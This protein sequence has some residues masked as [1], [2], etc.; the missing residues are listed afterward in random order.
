MEGE[1]DRTATLI[2]G[3]NDAQRRA[4]TTDGAPLAILAGA[5]SGKTRV[6]TRRI[7][8]RV[9]EGEIDASHVLAVT[10]TRKA[11]AE[12]RDRL[13]TLGLTSGVQAGT[14]HSIAFAQLRQ[15]WQERGVTPPSILDRKVGF[16]ARLVRSASSRQRGSS[17]LP[18]DLVSEIEWAK[19]RMVPADRY[20]E[21]AAAA[22]RRPPIDANEVAR[23]F[24]KYEE[25]KLARRMVDFDD[26]L[27]LATRDLRV[28]EGYAA[29]RR[30]RYRHLFVDEFQ[31]VN[32]LQFE[33]LRAWLGERVDLCVVGDPNQAIYSWNGADASYLADFDRYFPGATTVELSENYRSSPQILGVA[34][35]V[36]GTGPRST[37]FQLRPNRGDGPIPTVRALPDEHAEA[38]AIARRIR[39]HHAPGR[40]WSEQA[41]LVRTNAQLPVIEE[42]LR[43]ARVPFRSRGG[44]RLLEQPEVRETL[45]ALRRGP[46]HLSERL[47]EIEAQLDAGSGVGEARLSDER[48]ANVAEL[49]RL[50]REYVDLD[51]DGSAASFEAWLRS[52]LGNDE[53][54]PSTDAVD[55]ATF[56]AAKGLEW[57]VVHLA[58]LEE[59]FVPIHHAQT[60]PTRAEE[61]RL[62]YVALTR[63]ERELHCTWAERRAFASRSLQ[64]R[65]S[66]YLETISL[67][68]DL[69]G[70]GEE[71][72]D[73]TA[74][75]A[76]QRATLRLDDGIEP[77]RRRRP[78]KSSGPELPSGDRE[79]F[80]QLKA[81]RRAQA[82]LAD[83][84]AFVIFNDATLAEVATA[85]P[86]T[87]G[88]LLDVNGIG[89]V[90]A[91][92]FGEALLTIVAAN[93]RSPSAPDGPGAAGRSGRGRA[94]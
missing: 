64:R 68:I 82:K 10:F 52:T 20:A 41:V 61:R 19:A 36:L 85:R 59:G 48:A 72:I 14:F 58:G 27:R 46:G 69:L 38:R 11:A 6:L 73:L 33:L 74:A 29:A 5:G 86:A 84:P 75:V 87:A 78:T 51:A 81:W 21:A 15:R 47:D 76:R 50:G 56:H 55:L 25:E 92:R 65:P 39:D 42:A 8:R 54:G 7:A 43:V 1:L 23:V 30:W 71:P 57:S 34:N 12:L 4:V 26:L 91:Q 13:S 77:A 80:E 16:V 17:T 66:P 70:D 90:K 40:P 45:A 79:L 44:G 62:L 60:E 63:A 49:V 89:A 94:R 35:T 32:P 2:A 83:V 88:E 9:V 53:G 22:H 93:P 31:D 28:D 3:L 67:A 18:L 37:T 24:A